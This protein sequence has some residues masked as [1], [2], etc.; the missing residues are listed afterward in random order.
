MLIFASRAC[1]SA[2]TRT[3]EVATLANAFGS[4]LVTLG[5]AGQV[6]STAGGLP[7]G[8]ISSTLIRSP[9]AV[10]VLLAS[11]MRDDVDNGGAPIPSRAR[12]GVCLSW[13]A[14][15]MVGGNP[16]VGK[17]HHWICDLV[18]RPEAMFKSCEGVHLSADGHGRR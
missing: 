2:K 6:I 10:M 14:R 12:F 9:L 15:L 5:A 18:P 13:R 3:T 11:S 17:T 7:A 16:H 8:W 1:A 4:L